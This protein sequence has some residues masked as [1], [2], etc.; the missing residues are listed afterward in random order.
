MEEHLCFNSTS[1]RGVGKMGQALSGGYLFEDTYHISARLDPLSSPGTLVTSKNNPIMISFH[2]IRPRGV[3]PRTG[4]FGVSA[5]KQRCFSFAPTANLAE[6]KT[7]TTR[8]RPINVALHTAVMYTL[9][10]RNIYPWL[11]Q[12]FHKRW[13]CYVYH[14]STS[15]FKELP[16]MFVLDVDPVISWRRGRTGEV[17]TLLMFPVYARC[18]CCCEGM[19]TVCR[20]NWLP[21]DK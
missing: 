5:P 20:C 17:G 13:S 2:G 4:S 9:G 12:K 14:L 19:S 8:V 15:P 16:F 10:A 6:N 21:T 7:Q 11:T 18:E 3:F 1:P